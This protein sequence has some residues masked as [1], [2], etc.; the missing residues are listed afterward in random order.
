MLRRA[1]QVDASVRATSL[2][3]LFDRG[4][5]GSASRTWALVFAL[6]VC[7][8]C[9]FSVA[10]VPQRAYAQ[11]EDYLLLAD[12]HLGQPYMPSYNETEHALLWASEFDNLKAVTVAG[13]LTDRGS[14]E[15]YSEWEFLCASIC[16]WATR[17]QALGDHDTGKDGIYLESDKSLTVLK[18]YE[19]F[20]EIN[21]GA[22]TSYHEFEHA[23]VMTLG[24][25]KATGQWPLSTSMLDELNDRLQATARQGKIAIIIC[26]YAHTSD[27]MNM[28]SELAGVLRSYPNVIFVSGHRHTYSLTRQC[29][30]ASPSCK[31]TPY[32]REGYSKDTRYTFTSVGVNACSKYR[33]GSNS[34]ADTL[35]IDDNG[36]IV[37]SKW[38]LSEGVCDKTWTFDQV[39]S[40]VVV[41]AA[42][43][44]SSYL[45]TDKLTYRITFS[46]GGTY[47]GV[48]SGSTFTLGVDG[49]KVFTS[50]PAGVLVT[51][52]LVDAP[53][54]WSQIKASP[55]EV[56][57][58]ARTLKVE[59]AYDGPTDQNDQAAAEGSADQGNQAAAEGSAN[60]EKPF[61]ADSETN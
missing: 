55:V 5:R 48:P 60:Q 12:T 11:S 20:K 23:N 21:G 33:N 61:T 53:A 24:G 4:A 36:K 22:A 38:N 9:V 45:A 59:V 18:G 16:P 7:G 58:S 34:Y 32:T 30:V 28:R 14:A 17:I 10:T 52:Q 6:L 31:K 15:S 37:L 3:I 47:G 8:L 39:K 43:N 57:N 35:R 44:T 56:T 50:I 26:H 46:D 13:D 42:P 29:M 19:R 49:S 27:S 41:Q 40:S 1:G 2:M 25:I 54:G 51:A